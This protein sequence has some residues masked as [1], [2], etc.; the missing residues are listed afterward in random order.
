VAITTSKA[1]TL[2]ELLVVIAIIAILASMLLPA[3]GTVREAARSTA[4]LSNLRQIGMALSGYA[5]N[6]HGTYP[7]IKQAAP[8]ESWTNRL[9]GYL[10]IDANLDIGYRPSGK[11]VCPDFR[12]V[13]YSYGMNAYLSGGPVWNWNC[14]Q[15]NQVDNWGQRTW[16][17]DRRITLASQRIF[18]AD[19]SSWHLGDHFWYSSGTHADPASDGVGGVRHRGRTNALFCDLHVQG[20]PAAQMRW[21]LD[22]PSRF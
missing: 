5:D 8:F 20:G 11:Y 21:A 15:S 6:W 22:D 14:L 16:W 19:T 2:I 3:I 1:F 13:G 7:A 4:C 10:D 12:G 18:I 9:P 17:N